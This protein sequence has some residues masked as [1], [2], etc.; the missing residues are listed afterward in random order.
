MLSID[1]AQLY[2]HKSLDCWI[3]LWIIMDLSPDEQY[4]KWHILPGGFIPGP[5]KSKNLNLF[6]FPGLHHVCVLQSEGLHIWDTFQ[7]QRFISQLF[8]ALNMADGPAMAYL[9]SLIGHH[10]KFGCCL[11]CPVPGRHKP[12]SAHYYPALMKPVN[13]MMLGCDH[14]DLPFTLSAVSLSNLYLSNL[15]FLLKSPN[16]TQ[17]KKQHLE[18]GITK[19]IIFLGF[20]SSQILGIPGCFSSDIMHLG[21]FS[22]SDLLVT[23][24]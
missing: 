11:Y 16:E 20:N 3:Y 5:N 14:E 19:P 22:L 7:D 15:N 8:L 21:T 23:L 13:Y 1:S 18:T 24:W 10:G 2:A 9:N 4:K 17:Y 6:L 12:N